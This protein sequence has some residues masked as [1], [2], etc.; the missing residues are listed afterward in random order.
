MIRHFTEIVTSEVVSVLY[1]LTF[2]FFKGC[3]MFA[4]WLEKEVLRFPSVMSL[5]TI[6][7]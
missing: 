5:S 4:F 6:G 7:S 1:C 3:V 2:F